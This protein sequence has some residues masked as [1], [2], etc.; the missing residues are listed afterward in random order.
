MRTVTAITSEYS[1]EKLKA[2][3]MCLLPKSKEKK[4]EAALSNEAEEYDFYPEVKRM[5]TVFTHS[6]LI[7]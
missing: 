3:E 1:E 2:F 4:K 7:N 5:T 6:V